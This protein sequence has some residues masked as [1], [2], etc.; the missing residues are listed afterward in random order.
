MN[1]MCHEKIYFDII[2]FILIANSLSYDG[3]PWR[4]KVFKA[5]KAKFIT[6]FGENKNKED[7]CP[8]TVYYVGQ[9]RHG[10]IFIIFE[11]FYSVH[12]VSGLLSL[13]YLN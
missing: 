9:T 12:I 11:I 1:Q 5:V 3:W 4:W 8:H 10:G 13:L 7:L 6:D 2:Y